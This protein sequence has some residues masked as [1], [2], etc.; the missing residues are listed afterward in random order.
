MTIKAKEYV[1]RC[2]ECGTVVDKENDGFCKKCGEFFT[3]MGN[4]WFCPVNHWVDQSMFSMAIVDEF[5][6][7]ENVRW[8]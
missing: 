1:M 3:D 4:R 5:H 6:R 7:C 2:P 8:S